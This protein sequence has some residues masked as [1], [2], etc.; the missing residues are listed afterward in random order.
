MLSQSCMI[1]ACQYSVISHMNT[2]SLYVYDHNQEVADILASKNDVLK[3]YSLVLKTIGF[4][5]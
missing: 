1:N 4:I 2:N 3:E 5:K